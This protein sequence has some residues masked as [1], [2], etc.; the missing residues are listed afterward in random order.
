MDQ[1]KKFREISEEPS[2]LGP[3]ELTRSL[4]DVLAESRTLV[5]AVGFIFAFLLNAALFLQFDP[6]RTNE[7]LL[8]L[9]ALFCSLIALMLFSMPVIYHHLEFPYR[10]QEKFILRSHNFLSWGLAFF[11]LTM[12]LGL[13]LAFYRT[14]GWNAVFFAVATFLFLAVIYRLRSREILIRSEPKKRP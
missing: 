6:A 13:T 2:F 8:L 1:R 9:A 12:F 10:N 4:T 14:L 3:H 7:F 11:V 5:S